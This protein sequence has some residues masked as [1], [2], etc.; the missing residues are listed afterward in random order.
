M[1]MEWPT[2]LPLTWPTSLQRRQGNVEF[3]VVMCLTEN[4]GLYYRKGEEEKL[5]NS[6]IIRYIK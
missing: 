6:A 5:E 3:L 1:T 4:Q 2:S